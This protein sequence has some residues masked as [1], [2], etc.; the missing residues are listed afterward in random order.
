MEYSTSSLRLEAFQEPQRASGPNVRSY[1]RLFEVSLERHR[2]AL[3]EVIAGCELVD[4]LVRDGRVGGDGHHGVRA[5]GGAHRGGVDVHSV[6]AERGTHSA[7]HS[8]LV[9]VAEEGEV[10]GHLHVEALAV[11]R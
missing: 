8:G 10:V 5:L 9:A 11:D 2:A 1:R 7:D 6:V 3:V 4:D